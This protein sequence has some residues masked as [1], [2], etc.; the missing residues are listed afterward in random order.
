MK[1]TTF[2]ARAFHD[3][4]PCSLSDTLPHTVEEW[5]ALHG[6]INRIRPQAAAGIMIDDHPRLTAKAM[7]LDGRFSDLDLSNLGFDSGI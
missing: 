2:N 3:K 7:S 5:V 1:T 4:K 6:P